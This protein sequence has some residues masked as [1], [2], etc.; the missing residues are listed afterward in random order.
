MREHKKSK[1]DGALFRV[2]VGFVSRLTNKRR[3]TVVPRIRRC[4][5]RVCVVRGKGN[6]TVLGHIQRS[7]RIDRAVG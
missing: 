2:R 5:G 6:D 3:L 1:Y 7:R 4:G